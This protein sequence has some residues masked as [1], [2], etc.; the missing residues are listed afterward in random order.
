MDLLATWASFLSTDLGRVSRLRL[1]GPYNFPLGRLSTKEVRCELLPPKN[2]YK[3]TGLGGQV[4][5][6]DLCNDSPIK[7]PLYWPSNTKRGPDNLIKGAEFLWGE[8]NSIV[9]K[10]TLFEILKHTT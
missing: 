3:G 10:I 8:F 2:C 6:R 5:L 4:D 9:S 1:G 7:S